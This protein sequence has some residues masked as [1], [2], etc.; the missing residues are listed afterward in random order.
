VL[1]RRRCGS[2]VAPR[3]GAVTL[4]GSTV[5]A[6]SVAAEGGSMGRKRV[7]VVLTSIAE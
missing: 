7:A 5:A 3:S 1:A 6:R 2:T 4:C